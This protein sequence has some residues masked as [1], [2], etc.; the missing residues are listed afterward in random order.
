MLQAIYNQYKDWYPEPVTYKA[1]NGV[2][3]TKDFI[4][5]WQMYVDCAKMQRM[6]GDRVNLRKVLSYYGIV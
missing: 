2:E 5:I 4:D 6:P 1:W 3:H